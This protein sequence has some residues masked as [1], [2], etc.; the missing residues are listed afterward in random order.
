MMIDA[1]SAMRR[2]NEISKLG[3]G[4]SAPNPIVGAVI[5]G[6]DGQ[7]ISEGFHHSKMAERMLKLLHLIKL[8]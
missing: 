3:L 6:D 4:K 7:I 5:I 8:D 2:A 1:V